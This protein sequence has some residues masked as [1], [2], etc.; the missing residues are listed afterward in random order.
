MNQ[1]RREDDLRNRL[2]KLS[3][4][5]DFG[6]HDGMNGSCVECFYEDRD[7]FDRCCN[8]EEKLRKQGE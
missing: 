2:K 4:C 1:D 3:G 8:F 7:L 5:G 6:R